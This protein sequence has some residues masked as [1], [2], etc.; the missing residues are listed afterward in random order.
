MSGSSSL[1][2]TPR[3]RHVDG[4]LGQ[5]GGQRVEELR[6]LDGLVEVRGEALLL[7][8]RLAAAERGEEDQGQRRPRRVPPDRP[9]QGHAVHLRHV[10]V[11]DAD[12][13][14]LVGLDPLERLDGR[15]GGP[16]LHPP[17]LEMQGEDAAVGRVVVHHEDALAAE[18]RLDAAQVAAGR[19]RRLGGGRRGS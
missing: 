8:A 14:A 16:R 1:R 5:D 2:A 18:R 7:G 12:V 3:S 4:L 6:R 10:H 17:G 13:E 15:C 9:R 19:E 11:Q